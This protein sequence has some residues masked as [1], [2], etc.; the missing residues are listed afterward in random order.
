LNRYLADTIRN[1]VAL[2]VAGFMGHV[3]DR[4]MADS[5]VT[6]AFELSEKIQSYC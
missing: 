3:A 5:V 4:A 6:L 2:A 1:L